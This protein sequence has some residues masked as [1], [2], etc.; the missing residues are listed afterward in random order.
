MIEL[1][2]Q[3][4]LVRGDDDAALGSEALRG[5]NLMVVTSLA[6]IR[7][8]GHNHNR[9]AEFERRDD[10]AHSGVSH[11]DLGFLH[12]PLELRR[13]DELFELDVLRM[14]RGARNLGK[15]VGTGAQSSPLV[16]GANQAI[17]RL[18][19]TNSDENHRTDPP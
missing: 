12:Y 13:L 1:F 3:V 2:R 10:R 19:R 15:H 5:C 8:P 16:D 11:N 4:E 18:L 9:L 7:A 17:K 6:E 14:K